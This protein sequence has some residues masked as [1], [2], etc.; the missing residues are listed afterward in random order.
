MGSE[1]F[2]SPCDET[3]EN[4]TNCTGIVVEDTAKERAPP[5]WEDMSEVQEEALDFGDP[6]S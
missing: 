5:R 2:H 3:A 1:S 6:W 4:R